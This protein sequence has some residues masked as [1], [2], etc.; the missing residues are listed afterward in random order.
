[1]QCLVGNKT[2]CLTATDPR[3]AARDENL[4]E[5]EGAVRGCAYLGNVRGRGGAQRFRGDCLSSHQHSG[6]AVAITVQLAAKRGPNKIIS[7]TLSHK[8][9]RWMF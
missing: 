8:D 2:H 6:L 7:L 4:S 5:E 1:M 3:D 9:P